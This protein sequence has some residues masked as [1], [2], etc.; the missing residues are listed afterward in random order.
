MTKWIKTLPKC[1]TVGIKV[2][3]RNDEFE[4][5]VVE[6]LSEEDLKLLDRP[7]DESLVVV[8][9]EDDD[10]TL[11]ALVLTHVLEERLQSRN[12]VGTL[13]TLHRW[14]ANHQAH[15]WSEMIIVE[16]LLRFIQIFAF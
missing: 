16:S 12:D 14:D 2:R 10:E 4:Q 13:G 6:L 9:G 3:I 7:V 11:E 5:P 15:V 8:A 1:G